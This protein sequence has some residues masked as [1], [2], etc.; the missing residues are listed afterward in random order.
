[1]FLPVSGEAMA[2]EPPEAPA[3]MLVL[4]EVFDREAFM[5]GYASRLGPLYDRFGGEYTAIG[6]GVDVLEGD[7][8]PPSYVIGKWKS[9]EAA[10]AFWNSP[11]YDELRRA[12][13]DNNWGEF[14][15]ILVQGLPEAPTAE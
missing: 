5:Q 15:V 7:Y 12:R 13:I 2:S 14:D 4:G 1:K 10:L 6:G 8:D 3:Y 9:R 11:E